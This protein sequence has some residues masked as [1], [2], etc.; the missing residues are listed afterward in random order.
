MNQIFDPL[1]L[2]LAGIAIVVL[3]R[4][5]AVLG[6]RT[7]TERPPMETSFKPAPEAANA[8]V[9]EF[10]PNKTASDKLIDAE[11]AKPV[12]DGIAAEGSSLALGL[13]KIAKAESTFHPKIF[14]SGAKLAYEMV[15]EAF[16]NGDKTTLK[17]LLSRDVFDG[18]S[19]AIDARLQSGEKLTFQFVGFEKAEF[20][21]AVL[22][23]KHPPTRLLD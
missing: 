11:P 21:A 18:F 8:N 16:A 7:G 2:V 22:A 3:W 12:W 19:K 6:Q 13:E 10:P 20:T 14:L 1:N 9:L 5:R 15:V 4:L 23:E 17:N